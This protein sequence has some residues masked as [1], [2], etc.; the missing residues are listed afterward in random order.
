MSFG[1]VIGFVGAAVLIVVGIIFYRKRQAAQRGTQIQGYGPAYE[2]PKPRTPN[3]PPAD[4]RPQ[5]PTKE[6]KDLK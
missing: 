1:T 5:P 2:P 3:K 4:N 6:P